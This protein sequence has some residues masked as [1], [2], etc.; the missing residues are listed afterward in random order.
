MKSNKENMICKE[1]KIAR[2]IKQKDVTEMKNFFELKL[3]FVE[4]TRF[5][6]QEEVEK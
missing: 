4:S 2:K 5:L 1:V 3:C 6:N